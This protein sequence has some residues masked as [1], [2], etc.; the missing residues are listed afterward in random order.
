[1][2]GICFQ[3]VTCDAASIFTANKEMSSNSFLDKKSMAPK[4]NFVSYAHVHSGF[5]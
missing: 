1:M 5:K 4:L 2:K 3:R